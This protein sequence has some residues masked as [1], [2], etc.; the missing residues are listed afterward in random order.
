VS[1]LG[2]V[3]EDPSRHPFHGLQ[4]SAEPPIRA[5]V[6]AFTWFSALRHSP[7]LYA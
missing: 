3:S 4:G 1:V 2:T 5:A 6:R 7:G